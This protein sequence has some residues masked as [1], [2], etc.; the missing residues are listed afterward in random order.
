MSIQEIQELH[1]NIPPTWYVRGP[2]ARKLADW[3]ASS[4]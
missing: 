1:C 4:G 3:A 2:V